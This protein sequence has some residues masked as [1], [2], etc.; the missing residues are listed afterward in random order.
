MGAPFLIHESAAAGG[1]N[2]S[3]GW[4]TLKKPPRRCASGPSGLPRFSVV[5]S[6][7]GS[8]DCAGEKCRQL[9]PGFFMPYV[10]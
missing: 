8:I 4:K 7:T 5:D 9:R 3:N 2:A 1:G 10:T 6:F